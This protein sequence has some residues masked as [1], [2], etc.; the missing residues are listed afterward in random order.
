MSANQRSIVLTLQDIQNWS[1]IAALPLALFALWLNYLRYRVSV[2]E[3]MPDIKI[4]SPTLE[5][6]IWGNFVEVGFEIKN[7][8]DKNLYLLEVRVIGLPDIKFNNGLTQDATGEVSAPAGFTASECQ[9]TRRIFPKVAAI[10]SFGNGGADH[11]HG[12][13][14]FQSGKRT[15]KFKLEF[16]YSFSSEDEKK[17]RKRF[18]RELPAKQLG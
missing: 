6:S 5:D 9:I 7:R 18:I 11:S 13:L 12:E 8:S 2:A 10:D 15:G 17:Y 3:T 1:G 4:H 16:I 14:H